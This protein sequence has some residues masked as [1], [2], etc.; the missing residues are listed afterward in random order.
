MHDDSESHWSSFEGFQLGKWRARQKE[1][2]G[3]KHVPLLDMHEANFRLDTA[4]ELLIV[5]RELS[6]F[7][8]FLIC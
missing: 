6:Q 1:G 7:L 3:R 4:R 5:S 2:N 8:R